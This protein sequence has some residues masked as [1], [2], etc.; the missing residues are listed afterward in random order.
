MADQL[1]LDL[2]CRQIKATWI[3]NIRRQEKH[4]GLTT[5]NPPCVAAEMA[6]MAPGIV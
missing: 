2:C 6:A 4:S 3:S 5:E 1:D